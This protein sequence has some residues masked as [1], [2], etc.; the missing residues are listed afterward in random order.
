MVNYPRYIKYIIAIVSGTIGYYIFRS[1]NIK[2]VESVNSST[3]DIVMIQVG[4]FLLGGLI[5]GSTVL[6]MLT[7]KE[8]S[9]K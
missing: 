3:M 5:I 4:I 7:L 9:K 1:I 8:N 6:I 2:I